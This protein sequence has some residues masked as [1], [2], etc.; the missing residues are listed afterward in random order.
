MAPS[1]AENGAGS[2]AGSADV[3][4]SVPVSSDMLIS[5]L[6]LSEHSCEALLRA[7]LIVAPCTVPTVDGSYVTS[8]STEC[9]AEVNAPGLQVEETNDKGSNCQWPKDG[10]QQQTK[11]KR[12]R[13]KSLTLCQ[14]SDEE[15]STVMWY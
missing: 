4:P 6:K 2:I 1:A 7:G 12:P 8:A 13:W 11:R 15:C 3:G 5:R 14:S 9:A 10:Q